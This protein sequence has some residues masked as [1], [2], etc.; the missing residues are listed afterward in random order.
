LPNI[1]LILSYDGSDY[2][3]FQLQENAGSVQGTLEQALFQLLGT[4]VRVASA[5]RTDTGVHAEGQVVNFRAD[6]R[7]PVERLPFALNAVLPDDIVV[8]AAEIV[9][10]TFHARFSA[11]SKT[12]A[13]TIDNAP[14]PR[15]LTRKYSYHFRFPLNV[16]DMAA[17]ASSLLGIHDF[18]AF[19][20]TGSTVRTT[21][22]NLM[23]LDV[24]EHDSFVTITA[25][26]DG[27]LYNMVRIIAGTL[28]EV[29]SGRRAPDLVPV[30]ASRERRSAGPTAPAHGLVL[31]AVRY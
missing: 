28:L 18:V 11:V 7:I 10:D 26:A 13:Y 27:F 19:R 14:H 16:T 12:Y 23:R 5:G 24:A 29:G 31:K 8:R 6:T 17:A 21:V 25:E 22:R 3:G 4:A 1:K 2:H 15:V 20:A 30:L 9:P